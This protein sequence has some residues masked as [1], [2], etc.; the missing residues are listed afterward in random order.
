MNVLWTSLAFAAAYLV[1]SV[2][3]G[4]LA[5][6]LKGVDIREHGSRNIGATNAARVLGRKWFLIVLLL[7]ALKGA[8]PALLAGLFSERAGADLAL[9]AACGALCG[10]LFPVYLGFRG[11]KGVATG[12]GVVL[13]LTPAPGSWL[14]LAALLALGVFVLVVALT[15]MISAGSITAA[16]VLPLAYGLLLGRAALEPPSLW[17][18]VFFSV[19]GIFVIVK[20]RQNIARIVN[21]TENRIGRRGEPAQADKP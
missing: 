16:L 11:G 20:H 13:V 6:F 18:I 4:L 14:P 15:R 3:F 17:R 21:G 10:H 8:L 12:L 7:D 2:P 19:V 1:G 5:G 9:A